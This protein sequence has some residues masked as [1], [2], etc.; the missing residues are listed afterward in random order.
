MNSKDTVVVTS[1]S[2]SK[3]DFLI[4]RL[5]ESYS[6]IHL[7]NSGQTL[8]VHGIDFFDEFITSTRLYI[9]QS[10]NIFQLSFVK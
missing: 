5:Q 6:N 10:I 1:R 4:A 3:N 7:N 9:P 8:H 2:F